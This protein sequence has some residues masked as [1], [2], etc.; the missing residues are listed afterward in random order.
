MIC[1]IFSSN[2]FLCNTTR[3]CVI[4]VKTD[5]LH[6]LALCCV[7]AVQ[8]V[9]G[10]DYRVICC[11]TGNFFGEAALQNNDVRNATCTAEV[12]TVCLTLTKPEFESMLGPLQGLIAKVDQ[13]RNR[14]LK[15]KVET[16]ARKAAPPAKKYVKNL[17]DLKI[18]RTI[19][20]GTFG[21]V[22]L[23]QHKSSGE[24]IAMKCL[25]KAHIVESQQEK[26]IIAEKDCMAT[27]NHPF[28]LKL[29]GTFQDP[30]Q[31]Y[32]FLEIVQGGELWS[33][34]YQKEELKHSQVP[35]L[36]NGIRENDAR[37]Y[38]SCVTAGFAHIHNHNY[39]YRDLKPENLLVD[40]DGYLKI[41]DFGFAKQLKNGAKTHTLCGTPEYL[42]PELVLSR[43]HNHGVD[44]WALGILIYELI[45]GSTPFVDPD[46]TRIFVKIV[47]STKVLTFPQGFP[48]SAM[49]LIKN[50]LNVNCALRLGMLRNGAD[51]VK[52]HAWFRGIDW[53]KLEG[54]AYKTPWKPT[55]SNPLDDSNFDEYEEEDSVR[56][57]TGTQDI[58]RAF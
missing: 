34:L 37:M 3:F 9:G 56:E 44:Y 54:K 6:F 1:L 28:V 42:A 8:L 21:R 16:G 4:F 15:E 26:N 49:N 43:G 7:D 23:C 52:A 25:Q 31:L 39:S 48:R 46:Q 50:L 30:T 55:F 27:M 41:A 58:F 32:M 17:A 24:V 18:I 29:L 45:C 57:Y 11:N 22:K 2:V 14:E 35:A 38:A 40:A 12:D 19:G 13:R 20:T 53:S 47:H 51:D 10:C 33:L 5:F 36:E